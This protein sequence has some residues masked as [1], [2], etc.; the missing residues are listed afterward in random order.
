MSW[1]PGPRCPVVD[2]AAIA[3]DRTGK[4]RS[5]DDFVFYNQPVHPVEHIRHDGGSTDSGGA[6]ELLMVDLARLSPSLQSVVVTASVDAQSFGVVGG[7][8]V[9]VFNAVTG[10]A[11]IGFAI[12]GASSETAMICGE[13]YRHNGGWKFRA[14]GQGYSNGL[15]GLAADFGIDVEPDESTLQQVPANMGQP[16]NP[17]SA[18]RATAPAVRLAKRE[19]LASMERDLALTAPALLPMTKQVAV[20]LAKHRLGHHDA[21]V[22]LCID[23]SGSMYDLFDSGQVQRLIERVL[24]MGLRFDDDGKVDVFAFSDKAVRIGELG[25]D[26]HVGFAD[27]IWQGPSLGGGTSY[28][29]AMRLIRRYY[30]GTAAKRRTPLHADRPVYVMWITDGASSDERLSVSHITSSSYE[31]IFWQF[32]AIDEEPAT[33]GMTRTASSGS[34]MTS[35]EDWSTMSRS[36]P[37]MI[38]RR[39]ATTRCSIG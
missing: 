8:Q 23:V 15:S 37:S 18:T 4:V 6:S 14:I 17:V 24:A 3:L 33:N 11:L 29:P 28:G 32:M 38:P 5:D 10:E 9:Q 30:F 34:S 2:A 7:L 19:R 31:P 16:V 13:L 22:A 27:E 26:N 39:S 1:R 21:R 25:T 20:C 36:S 12:D 35:P